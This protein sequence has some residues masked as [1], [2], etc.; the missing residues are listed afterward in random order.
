MLG[1]GK[2][3]CILPGQFE[4]E[5]RQ[6]SDEAGGLHF[7]EAEIAEFNELAAEIGKPG[8]EVL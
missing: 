8:L 7:T 5:A 2:E 3:G 6:R 1:H 4:A